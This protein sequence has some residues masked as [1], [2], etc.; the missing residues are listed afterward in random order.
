MCRV[1][2]QMY[3]SCF[4]QPS[5]QD[6]WEK[7]TMEGPEKACEEGGLLGGPVTSHARSGTPAQHSINYSRR[8]GM[9]HATHHFAVT[10]PCLLIDITDIRSPVSKTPNR[11]GKVE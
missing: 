5:G 3:C 6:E 8:L 4:N 11:D 1:E 10:E 2:Q 7:G 9:L